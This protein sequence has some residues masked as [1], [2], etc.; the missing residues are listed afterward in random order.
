MNPK[1]TLK[2]PRKY[3]MKVFSCEVPWG[4]SHVLRVVFLSQ[5][6]SGSGWTKHPKSTR[7]R[8]KA[9]AKAA[10]PRARER[11][12]WDQMNFRE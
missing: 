4:V 11:G 9:R 8:A 1:E 2:K 6:D 7:P 3:H 12:A 5:V 10:R